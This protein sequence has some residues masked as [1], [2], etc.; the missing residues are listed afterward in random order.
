MM[1][2]SAPEL[3]PDDILIPAGS[4][5]GEDLHLSPVARA[6]FPFTIEVKHQQMLNINAALRQS[7]SHAEGKP[8]TPLLVFRKNH[9]RF[10]V[11]L[12]FVDFLKLVNK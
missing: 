11:A 12:L 6:R 4:A 7:A 10:Y 1:L 2:E 3:H 8:H 5:T 9:G